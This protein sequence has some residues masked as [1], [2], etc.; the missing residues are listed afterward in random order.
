MFHVKHACRPG[1]PGCPPRRRVTPRSRS[2]SCA[3]EDSGVAMPHGSQALSGL[4]GECRVN[5]GGDIVRHGCEAGQ[6]A[7][8]LA[9]L[10]KGVADAGA[11][12]APGEVPVHLVEEQVE[13]FGARHRRGLPGGGRAGTFPAGIDRDPCSHVVT[14]D[15]PRK[16]AA[17][18]KADTSAS[19]TASAA[20]SGLP[21]VRRATAHRRSR[22]RRTLSESLRLLRDVPGEEVLI[23]QVLPWTAAQRSAPF[24]VPGLLSR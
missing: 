12:D 24:T 13:P 10:G 9:D 2:V 23:G 3:P 17:E 22:C 6:G 15:R 21:S 14:A 18:R 20:S 1:P 8:E 19:C 16:T 5:A 4:G 7:E 11:P